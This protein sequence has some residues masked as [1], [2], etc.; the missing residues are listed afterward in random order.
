MIIKE[1]SRN[2]EPETVEK[3][4]FSDNLC[5]DFAKHESSESSHAE[6]FS[7]SKYPNRGTRPRFGCVCAANAFECA[8][9]RVSVNIA[10]TD[11]VDKLRLPETGSLFCVF[12][13]K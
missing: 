1:A 7:L 2:G 4:R 5:F 6:T 9:T 8:L 10:K 13:E 11:F 12:S 3:L